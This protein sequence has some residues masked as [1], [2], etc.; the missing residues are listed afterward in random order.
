M[1]RKKTDP[2]SAKPANIDAIRHKETRKNIPTEELRDFVNTDESAP[3]TM[4]YPR[5]PS[6]VWKGKDDQDWH[7]L[8]HF[9][10]S[11]SWDH[12]PLLHELARQVGVFLAYASHHEHAL[13]DVRLDLPKSCGA[14][15]AASPRRCAIG[16]GTSWRWRCFRSPGA[17]CRMAGSPGKKKGVTGD[18]WG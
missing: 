6:L 9:V 17:C 10:G 1:A 11:S 12:R 4:L 5:D 13:V 15:G 8:P 16:P 2:K 3:K 7:G 18:S 14:S